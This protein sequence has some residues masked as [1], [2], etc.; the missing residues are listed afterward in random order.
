MEI[1][2]KLH[3]YLEKIAAGQGANITEEVIEE[4][5]ERCKET[6]RRF[7]EDTTNREFRLRMSNIGKDVRS[8]WL[9]KEY[10]RQ[11]KKVSLLIQLTYG[12]LIEHLFIA[13]MR[14]AGNININAV[15]KKVSLPLSSTVVEGELDAIIDDEV[16]DFKTASPFSYDRKFSSLNTVIES[17]DFG[18]CGQGVGYSTGDGKPFAGWFV[19]NKVNGEFKFIDARELNRLDVRNKYMEDFEYKVRVLDGKLPVPECTGVVD[20][21]FNKKPTGRKVLN[22]SCSYC[23]CKDK[24]HDDLQYLPSLSSTAKSRPW[25]Y[26]VD[27]NKGDSVGE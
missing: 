15:N 22:Y 11:A 26:Y 27:L 9:E 6:L 24:C 3:M 1:D 25:K 13:L 8:L 14:S 20:E 19:I 2:Q 18:Y 4:F 12:H 5:G 10:G 16:Y 21:V 23:P 17:D 7:N